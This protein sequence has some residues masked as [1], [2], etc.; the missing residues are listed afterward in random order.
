MKNQAESITKCCWLAEK[1]HRVLTQMFETIKFKAAVNLVGKH[2]ESAI[3]L[4][5]NPYKIS[6]IKNFKDL[7]FS[8]YKLLVKWIDLESEKKAFVTTFVD[9]FIDSDILL[10]SVGIMAGRDTN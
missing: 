7:P 8:N 5:W 2:P 10:V 4:D 3:N 6:F 1:S 9:K